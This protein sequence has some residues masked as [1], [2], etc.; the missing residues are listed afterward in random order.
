VSVIGSAYID[1]SLRGD[2]AEA[3]GEAAMGDGAPL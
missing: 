1:R 2:A 3:S